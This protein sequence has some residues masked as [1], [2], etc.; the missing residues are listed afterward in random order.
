MKKAPKPLSAQFADS[1]NK[2]EAANRY[3]QRTKK[4]NTLFPSGMYSVDFGMFVIRLTLVSELRFLL[5]TD[6]C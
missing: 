2:Q 3:E 6:S 4:R 1:R 5:D